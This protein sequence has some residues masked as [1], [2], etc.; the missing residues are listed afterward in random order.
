MT[1]AA[2]FDERLQRAT[3]AER[4]QAARDALAI[5][6]FA[7]FVRQAADLG[8]VVGARRFAWSWHNQV[9]ADEMEAVA[10][11]EVKELVICI[12]PGCGKSFFVSVLFQAWDWLHNPSHRT[13]VLSA[14]IKP[15]QRDALYLRNLIQTSWY[16]RLD[17]IMVARARRAGVR[18][19]RRTSS[20]PAA[21]SACAPR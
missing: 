14:N 13:A 11:G 10:R 1:P 16:R 4:R 8:A 7:D 12:P 18:T 19:R 15:V 9:I 17:A 5:D 6:H 2:S 21:A 3:P 20:R